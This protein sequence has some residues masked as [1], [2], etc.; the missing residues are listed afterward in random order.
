MTTGEIAMLPIPFWF[1]QRQCKAE[2]VETNLYRITG[3]NLPECFLGLR[4]NEEGNY[5]G[6]LRFNKDG[7]DEGVTHEAF[8]SQYN[9]WEAAFELFRN[10][11]IL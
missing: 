8:D 11:V 4:R 5:C 3:P 2:E 7:E 10:K 9:A 6:F 1:P